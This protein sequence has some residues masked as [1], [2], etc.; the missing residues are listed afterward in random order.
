PSHDWWCY[1][2]QKGDAAAQQED[3]VTALDLYNQAVDAGQRAYASSEYMPFIQ[4]AAHQD[5]WDLAADISLQASYLTNSTAQ[6][7]ETWQAL[8]DDLT[9]PQDLRAHLIDRF[10]CTNLEE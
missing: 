1:Y 3:W 6:I 2:Y 10:Q 9:L 5:A 7:C 8:Q 4:A